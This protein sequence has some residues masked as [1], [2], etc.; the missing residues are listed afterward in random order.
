MR[1]PRRFVLAGMFVLCFI[2]FLNSWLVASTPVTIQYYTLAWQPGVV[3]AVRQTVKEWNDTHPDIQVEIVWGSWAAANEFLLTSFLGGDAPDIFHQDAVMCY[4]YGVLGFAEP[5]N[6]HLSDEALADVPQWMWES[7]SDYDGTIYG[8]P[9]LVETHAVF[10]NRTLFQEA[11]IEVPENS[12]ASWEQLAEYAQRLTVRD[13][14]GQVT[15][16]GLMAS[17]MEKFPWMLITQN[18]GEVVHR[19]EDGTWYVQVDA[20]AREALK[21]YCDLVT[22]WNVMAPEAI[23]SDYTYLMSGF[24]QQR[25][26]MIIFGCWNRRILVQWDNVDWGMLHLRG[27]VNNITSGGPQ[28]HGM[29]AGS[30]HKA[31]AAMF[32]D[33]ISSRDNVVEI[34]YPDWI[35]PARV[36]GQADP[37]F[38]EEEYQWDLAQSWLDY[39]ADVL[40]RMPTIIAFDMRVIVPE[41][42]QV[43]LGRKSLEDAIDAIEKNGNEYLQK[44]GLQ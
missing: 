13:E 5:L 14:T 15:T 11:G 33:F 1:K 25:Y 40:P 8:Y 24:S 10:Y 28:A 22:E 37:R 41:L 42:E 18:G 44:T 32:L 9:F 35:F 31:E 6:A 20:A 34:A 29:W 43:M 38:G 3:K 19:R 30:E 4:E 21:Y 17:V 2:V 36:S 39:S 12:E 27:P 23:S 7:A 16:W 26:A